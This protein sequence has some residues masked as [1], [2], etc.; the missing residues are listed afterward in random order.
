MK[1][2]TKARSEFR[3]VFMTMA[4]FSFVI[5]LLMLTMPL[6]MLQIY[7]RI[8]PSRS[9]ETL[10]FLSI[11]AV[12]ALVVLG[13]LEAVRN[14]VAARAAARLEATLGAETL[15]TVIDR[16]RET[17]GDIQP[18][19]DLTT[20]RSTIS[21][22]VIFALL[23]L[24]FAPVFIGF[25]YF[26]HPHL[27]WIT[28]VGAVVLAII[29][30]LNQWMST[31]PTNAAGAKTNAALGAAQSFARN[32][33]SLRA[34]GMVNNSISIWGRANADALIAQDTAARST[35]IFTGLSRTIRTGL[36]IAVL[37][38]GAFLVLAG[39]MT[40]G[41]IFAASII[42]GRGLQPI[43]Q[44]IGGWRQY[45]ATWSAW[46]RLRKVLAETA[47][48]HKRTTMPEAKGEITADGVVVIMPGGSIDSAILKR[49]SFGLHPGDSLGVVG[50]SGA[51]KS[52]LARVLVG[53]V[54][55]NGGKVRLDGA[56]LS[57]W[58]P[59]DLGHQIGYLSQE[60]ELLPGTV[61]ENIARLASN[62]D[63][64]SVLAAA[65]KAGVHELILNLPDGYDTRLGPGGFTLSGGQ[66]QRVAL[67]RAFYGDPKLMILDEPNANLDEEGD[68]A[69]SRALKA[70]KD[71]GTTVVLITQRPQI[72]ANVDKILRLQ[73]GTVDFFGSREEFITKLTELK[74]QATE[75]QNKQQHPAPQ[76]AK[77]QMVNQVLP[78]KSEA[79][80]KSGKDKAKN[81]SELPEK[82]AVTASFAP[83]MRAKNDH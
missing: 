33:E 1:L 59:E 47:A 20:V 43:D 80:S 40:A 8:L 26:L 4:I 53:A 44:V 45:V 16:G 52:T 67:A 9:T 38:Y 77:P 76:S 66:R 69:L 50:P 28:L 54:P 55:A 2:L 31:A 22:R 75:Q 79:G 63:S 18:M 68:L 57:N 65:Q 15:V 39:E 17:Q 5:N 32:S 7:D 46:K 11:I 82:F 71:S 42:S 81:K 29:A 27:F 30:I 34:M 62:A 13:L 72:L 70:A 78:V 41:M 49:V 37:G 24:P 3:Q 83:E 21:S 58:S 56:E 6:Y 48:D 73:S 10:T 64:E 35:A 61:A 36:Q 12:V 60:I 25:L 19:R 74:K 14:V 51:G 23:D